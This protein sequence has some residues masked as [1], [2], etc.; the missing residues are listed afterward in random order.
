MP[1]KTYYSIGEVSELAG[2]KQHVLRYWESE[3][4]LLKPRKNRA[5]NRAYRVRDIKVVFL[6]KRLLYEENYTISRARQKLKFDQEFVKV[7]L[8]L[9]LEELQGPSDVLSQL[10]RGLH[11][12]LQMVEEL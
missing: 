10:K 6:L 12:L 4:P 1:E 11:V 3:F 7:Q 2:V 8:H 5:G 9:S